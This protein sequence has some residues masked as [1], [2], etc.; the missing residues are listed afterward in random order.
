MPTPPQAVRDEAQRG[1]DW[2]REYNRG[3]TMVGVARAR[4]L[5]RGADV[6]ES[7]LRR[8]VSFFARHE[9]DKR[10][11]GFS[12]GEDGYPSPGRIAWALWG[13]DAGYRWARS[14]TRNDT[15]AKHDDNTT[16]A[17]KPNRLRRLRITRVD[18]VAAGANPDAHVVLY[19]RA[20]DAANTTPSDVVD[21][22][23]TDATAGEQ[24]PDEEHETMTTVDRETLAPEVAALISEIEA[25]RDAALAKAA[26]IEAAAIEAAAEPTEDEPTEDEV[27]KALDPTVRE[28]IEKAETER[29]ELADRIAKM[30][31]EALTAS[32]VAKAA[33]YKAVENDTDNLGALL[34]DV[35]KH[36]ATESAQTLERVLKAASARLDEAHRL[37]TAEIGTAAGLDATDAGRQIEALAKARADQTGETL[38]VATAAVLNDNPSLYEQA[39]TERG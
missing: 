35:A 29:A 20:D 38:P 31:D 7:T 3:G 23:H 33:E 30:E 19:K 8:M 1:L 24:R 4:D 28:R 17:E 22:D 25:E 34:K 16:D 14:Q 18:R 37:I 10:G 5:A 15:M 11:Q 36:C 6:S 12:P 27:L 9:V 32:F 2:R 13:G 26:D 21:Y 39:R